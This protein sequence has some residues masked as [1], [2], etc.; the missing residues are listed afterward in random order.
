MY[1]DALDE[2]QGELESSR[3]SSWFLSRFALLAPATSLLSLLVRFLNFDK[4][5]TSYT[6]SAPRSQ[7]SQSSQAQPL[8]FRT[9][10]AAVPRILMLPGYTQNAAIFSEATSHRSC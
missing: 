6:S 3:V 2:L 1:V 4:R 5:I 10:M 8:A 9:T 7:P